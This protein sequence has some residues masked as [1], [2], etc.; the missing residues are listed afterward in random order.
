MKSQ[1]I[2][3]WEK[4]EKSPTEGYKE[5]FDA[6]KD[7]L[8]KKLK[9]V[10]PHLFKK[11]ETNSEKMEEKIETKENQEIKEKQTKKEKKSKK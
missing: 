4:I 7:F 1:T 11:L 6:E 3:F 10:A 9:E 5:F 8:L 2:N